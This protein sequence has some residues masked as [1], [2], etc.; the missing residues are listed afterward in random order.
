VAI[1]IAAAVELS[2][3]ALIAIVSRSTPRP[4]AVPMVRADSSADARIVWL[5]QPGPGGGGGGGGNHMPDPPR[6]AERSGSDRVTIP[7]APPRSMPTPSAA[8]EPPRVA[9]I[10]IPAMPLASDRSLQVGSIDAPPRPPS[11]SQGPGSRGGAGT[12]P[13]GGDGA[14]DGPGYRDGR[15][16]NTGGGVS[17]PGDGTTWPIPL[18]QPRPNYT[19]DAMRAR[20][21]GSVLL[22][23]IV[24]RDGLVD[25]VR[26]IRALDTAFGLDDEAIKAAKRWRFR[27]ATRMGVPVPVAITIELTF[28]IR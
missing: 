13:L 18:S 5:H 22:E 2:A 11:P 20:L 15:D 7:A 8:D 25:E 17:R 28:T 14:G 4:S 1:A 23:C 19:P 3:I 16:G 10:E 24:G 27:P 6:R 12:G 26:V 9:A 21:Q